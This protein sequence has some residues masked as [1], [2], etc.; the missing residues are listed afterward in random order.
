MNFL[1]INSFFIRVS[2]F[3]SWRQPVSGRLKFGVVVAGQFYGPGNGGVGVAEHVD[4]EL[5]IAGEY[6]LHPVACYMECKVDV[7]YPVVI[8]GKGDLVCESVCHHVFQ[9]GGIIA[10]GVEGIQVFA[11][12]GLPLGTV[13]VRIDAGAQVVQLHLCAIADV[14]A[15]DADGG[16]QQQEGNQHHDP[17]H[18]KAGKDR[19]IPAVI[20][21]GIPG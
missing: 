19:N 8:R 2:S 4:I 13:G 18:K 10:A 14:D 6:I 1:D 3:H 11:E 5:D 12:I 15:G 16:I 7:P 17:H 20:P 9:H 21:E